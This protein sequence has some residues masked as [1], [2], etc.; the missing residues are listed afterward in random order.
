[1]NG[2]LPS[3]NNTTNNGGAA[4]AAAAAARRGQVVHCPDRDWYGFGL[5]WQYL[6]VGRSI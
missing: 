6:Q 3:S 1:M 2:G 4:A 5:L